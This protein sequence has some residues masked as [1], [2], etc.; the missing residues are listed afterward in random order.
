[1]CYERVGFSCNFNELS[2]TRTLL[3]GIAERTPGT[4]G[5]TL[6]MA[7]APAAIE[8]CAALRVDREEKVW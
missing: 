3:P 1:L 5:A 8:M 7:A 6:G 2:N 4:P